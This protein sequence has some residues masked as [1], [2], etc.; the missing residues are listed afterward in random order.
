M[1]TSI[2]I[3]LLGIILILASLFFMGVLILSGNMGG[4]SLT[5]FILGVLCCI[6][7]FLWDIKK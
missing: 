7:G 2:K 4:L 6:F 1:M 3:I 5:L